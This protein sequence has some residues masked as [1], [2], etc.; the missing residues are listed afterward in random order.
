[1]TVETKSKDLDLWK[2][3][4]RTKSPQ[5]L[6]ALITQMSPI[7]D[8]EV[9]KWS[10]AMSASLL[11]AEGVRIAV[12]AFGKFDPNAGTA[13]ST[14]VASRLPKMSRIVYS[15]QNIA[16]LPENK[17]LLFRAYNTAQSELIDNLGRDPTTSELA[18]HLGWSMKKLTQFQREAT[19]KEYVESEAHPDFADEKHEHVV[20][21]FHHDLPPMQ[22]HIFEYST[23]YGG[24]AVLSNAQIMKKLKLTQ[25]QL[26][27][28]KALLVKRVQEL[29]KTR[30][31]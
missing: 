25:G 31:V 5:D 19:R 20:D 3:W 27:Y 9:R 21:F 24:Q 12:E 8:R 18:D 15:N 4:K 16:R 11:R 29:Q 22:Q 28:Q 17:V 23:G 26:S 1:M 14:F 7:I 2:T 6:Q 10:G 30:G 13:I